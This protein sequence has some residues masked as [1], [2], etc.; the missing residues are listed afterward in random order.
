MFSNNDPDSSCVK[1]RLV[2]NV[3]TPCPCYFHTDA[4]SKPLRRPLRAKTLP[5]KQLL[6]CNCGQHE[7]TWSH[8]DKGRNQWDKDQPL[9]H[10]GHLGTKNENYLTHP[11]KEVIGLR[12]IF[13][14]TLST[15]NDGGK[16]RFGWVTLV[17]LKTLHLQW[18]WSN[19]QRLKEQCYKV[20]HQ[21]WW[22]GGVTGLCNRGACL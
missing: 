13:A 17:Y 22:R 3:W 14:Y 10:T 15:S 19:T 18:R 6:T 16:K 20:L 5:V 9:H 12:L 2:F 21:S 1:I 11:L 7:R 4:I 8:A